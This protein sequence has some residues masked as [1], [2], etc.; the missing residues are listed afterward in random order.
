MTHSPAAER[1]A[2]EG[3][4]TAPADRRIELVTI[5][6]ELLLGYTIDTNAAYLARRLAAIGVEIVRRATVG[7]DPATIAAAVG[8]A[9]AR[10]GAVVTTGGLG[11]TSDDMTKPSI[12]ALFGRGMRLDEGHLAW[13]RE[14]WRTLFR[15][16]MP[17]SNVQQAMIPEGARILRNDH[18]SAPGILLEDDGG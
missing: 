3:P 18:G 14:R 4:A 11:P 2:A 10:T 8:E 17:E 15:R 6:D 12:A 9:L 5:G 1:P 16:E 13:M 7:D